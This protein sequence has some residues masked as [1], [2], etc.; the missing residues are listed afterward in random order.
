MRAVRSRPVVGVLSIALA[1]A[2]LAACGGGGGST[3]AAAPGTTTAP[4]FS[5]PPDDVTVQLTFRIRGGLA[6]LATAQRKGFFKEQNINVNFVEGAGSLQVM[7]AVPDGQNVFVFGPDTAAAQAISQGI[8]LVSVAT[9]QTASPIGLVGRPGVKLTTPK[10]LEGLRLA[11]VTG[12]TFNRI[13][14]AFAAKNGVDLSKV[15]ATN[16]DASART[17]AIIHGDVDVASVN[18]DNELALVQS[19]LKGNLPTLSIA[20]FGFPLLGDGVTVRRSLAEQKPDLVKRFL[21]ALQKGYDANQTT[22]GLAVDSTLGLWADKMPAK[23]VSTAQIAVTLAAD[24]QA[25]VAGQPYGYVPASAWD[26]TLSVLKSTGGI[27]NQLPTD[28]YFTN[29]YL[30]AP[31]K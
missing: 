26:S 30:P 4:Q 24:K 2:L 23:D 20:D 5:G 6:S 27:Q 9:Y 8:P 1:G 22:P 25:K 3:K 19:E 21:A 13:F 16:M 10:D 29:S 12:D 11:M 17:N 7:S 28:Q 31:L 15:Q 18:F 14:P